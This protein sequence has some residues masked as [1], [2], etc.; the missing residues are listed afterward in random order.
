[1]SVGD[2]K[3]SYREQVAGGRLLGAEGWLQG[4]EGGLQ[5]EALKWLSDL[6]K[7]K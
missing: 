5:P 4:A 6:H 3:N 2:V 7:T 1:L